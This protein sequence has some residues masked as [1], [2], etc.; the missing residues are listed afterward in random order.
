MAFIVFFVE[1]ELRP[2]IK[3][4]IGDEGRVKPDGRKFLSVDIINLPLRWQLNKIHHGP[5]PRKPSSG[6]DHIPNS[7]R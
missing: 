1:M 4:E 7:I 3:I 2:H 5:A 6:L